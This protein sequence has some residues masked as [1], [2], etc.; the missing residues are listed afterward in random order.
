MNR[1]LIVLAIAIGLTACQPEGRIYVEHQELSSKVSWSKEDV[2]EFKVPIIDNSI[3]Y[4]MS[5]AFRY[6]NGFPYQVL[7]VKVTE[8]SPSGEEMIKSYDLKVREEN[9]EYIGEPGLDIWDSD[10][11]IE[12]N[13]KYEEK[14]TYTY[15]LEHNMPDDPLS[16]AMEIGVILDKAK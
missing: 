6:V 1:L 3:E 10:H 15:V 5:L 14:G 16:F 8:I 2:R 13:K 11:L 12:P 4:D 7:K 9:G